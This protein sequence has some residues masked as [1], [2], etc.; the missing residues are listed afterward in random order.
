MDTS[1]YESISSRKA[2][3]W[4]YSGVI[5]V[6]DRDVASLYELNQLA[7]CLNEP[8]QQAGLV[9]FSD[10]Q[11]SVNLTGTRAPHGQ[12]PGAVSPYEQ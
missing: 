3:Q 1:G 11:A 9:S 5:N 7:Q 10:D 4:L 12:I 2:Q 6:E 8:A